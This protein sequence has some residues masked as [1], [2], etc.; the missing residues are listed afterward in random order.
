MVFHRHHFARTIQRFFSFPHSRFC[1]DLQHTCHLQGRDTTT[2]HVEFGVLVDQLS[3]T[4]HWHVVLGFRLK[5]EQLKWD[6][7]ITSPLRLSS[8]MVAA[9]GLTD[10]VWLCV[11]NIPQLNSR[12]SVV[13]RSL[14][15]YVGE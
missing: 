6:G 13:S 7:T 2:F 15:G 11:K 10:H 3:S 5:L 12:R 9:A 1:V 8:D 4:G 14:F